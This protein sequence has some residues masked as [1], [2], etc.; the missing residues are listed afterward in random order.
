MCGK[1]YIVVAMHAKYGEAESEM[2]VSCEVSCLKVS[3]YH[4]TRSVVFYFKTPS[5]R[6]Q[7]RACRSRS[8][9]FI[10]P[11]G[12]LCLAS[13][14][15]LTVTRGV[16]SFKISSFYR[17]EGSVVLCLMIFSCRS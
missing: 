15:L 16:L 5:D 10:V 1:G 4:T 9:L 3:F 17:A 6:S 8:P 14:A 12:V 11:P 2:I 13:K 7:G